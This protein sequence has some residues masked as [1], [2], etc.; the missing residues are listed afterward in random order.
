MIV[1]IWKDTDQ[2]VEDLPSDRKFSRTV[3]VLKIRKSASSVSTSS[4]P[5]RQDS[6][7]I[8]KK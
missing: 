3:H 8:W 6:M 1:D 4:Y 2:I 7:N 5:S